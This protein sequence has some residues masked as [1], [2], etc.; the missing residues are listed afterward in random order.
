MRT[1]LNLADD[2]LAAARSLARE[3]SRSI[4]DVIS[5]LV[6]I[7]LRRGQVELLETEDG[8]PAFEIREGSPIF[9]SDQVA[10]ALDDVITDAES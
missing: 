7:G 8:I 10:E 9:G 4:G 1:T 2:V 6:R 3:Q 5:E